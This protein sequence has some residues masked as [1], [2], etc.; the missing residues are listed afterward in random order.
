MTTQE[1]IRNCLL[2]ES[3]KNNKESAERLGLRDTSRIDETKKRI[4]VGNHS[5]K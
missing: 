3:M 2:L 1:R 4:S 5:M